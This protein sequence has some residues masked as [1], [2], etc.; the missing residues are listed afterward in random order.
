[1]KRVIIESPYAG[2]WFIRRRNIKYAR[3]AMQDSLRRDEAPF[4]S[5]LLYT[6]VLDDNNKTERNT[7][8][9]AGL[10]WGEKAQ[11]T[12]I[13]TDYGVT[14]G[15]CIGKLDADDN[16]RLIT[17]RRIGKNPNWIRT[18]SEL[19]WWKLLKRCPECHSDEV[20]YENPNTSSGKYI[21]QF[22]EWE[23]NDETNSKAKV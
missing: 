15:M 4:L 16:G 7:G 1:M 13:Y 18:I 19:F 9:D 22:C 20:Y 11:L 14:D 21:C 5:H 2:N 6:Q 8:I 10:E 23:A 12:A 3:R 17:Y